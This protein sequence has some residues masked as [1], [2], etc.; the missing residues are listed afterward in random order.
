MNKEIKVSDKVE[1]IKGLYKGYVGYISSCSNESF[2]GTQINKI[3][4]LR[5]EID[6]R[7]M[8]V[9]FIADELRLI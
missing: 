9:G 2:F 5:I 6:N 4:R 7:I 3:Y 8:E 1:V